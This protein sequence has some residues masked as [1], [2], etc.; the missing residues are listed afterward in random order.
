MK[1]VVQKEYGG[2]SVLQFADIDKPLLG[3]DELLI[4]VHSAAV[5]PGDWLMMTGRPLLF[6]PVFGLR[7]PRKRIPGFDLAGT[8]EAVGP[9][10]TEFQPG[11]E[12]FG[13]A[14]NGS[15]AEYVTVPEDSVAPRPANLTLTQSAVV[16][17]S[18][19]AALRGLRD[20]GKLRPGQHVLINGASG[21]IGTFAVQIAKALGAE[22]TGVCS[23]N[24]VDLVRT[25]G[26][27][28][29]VDYTQHDFTQDVARY[30]LI[31]DNV[32]N[33]SLADC[34]RALT[35]DGVLLTNNGTSGN[36]WIGPLGRMAAA[37]VLSLFVSKQGRPFYAPIRKQDLID[38]K[39]LIEAG[40]IT[41]VIDKTFP[42][43]QTADAMD[44]VGKGHARG[45]VAITL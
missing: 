11:D 41:P 14:P 31:L 44:H 23:T 24:N 26:A 43:A 19:T 12:V 17:V 27:D 39:E 42:L 21:G 40:K 20:A 28:H 37:A 29:V 32:A 7:R 5:H 2:P 13:E 3:G 4:R 38:L 33:H 6:R 30:D 22:V 15:C 8:V 35:E 18:G 9:K 25:L 10:A 34:R 36:R 45:K 16:A 1:A